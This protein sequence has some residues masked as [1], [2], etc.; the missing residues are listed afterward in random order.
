MPLDPESNNWEIIK[1]YRSCMPKVLPW[2]GRKKVCLQSAQTVQICVKATAAGIATA[3]QPFK[4]QH[5]TEGV[6]TK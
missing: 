1:D 5:S 2:M 4:S 3:L 6:R